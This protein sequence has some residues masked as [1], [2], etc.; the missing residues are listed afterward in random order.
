MQLSKTWVLSLG[1]FVLGCPSAKSNTDSDAAA[2]V[3]TADAA[4]T[5]DGGAG[6]EDV[7][8]VYALDP[9][10]PVDPRAAKLCAGL[11]QLAEKKRAECCHTTPGIVLV[12]ECTRSLSAALR[13]KAIELAMQDVDTCLSAQEKALT[14]CD[15]VGP[16]P[17]GPPA[18]CRGIFEGKVAAGQKC[19]SSL[20]CAGD[21]HCKGLGPT[22]VGTCAKPSAEGESCGGTV[23][24]LAGFARQGDLGKRHPECQQ[25]CIKHKCA[26]PIGEGGVCLV[27]ADCEDGTECIATDTTRPSSARKC[28]RRAPARAGETCPG[29]RCEG[30]LQC[31]RGKC[32]E[33]KAGGETCSDDF[34][35][36]G[37]C[38]KD[39]T[40]RGKCGPRC[41]VR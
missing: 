19:R 2:P 29:G 23:D 40:G 26:A 31:I 34:E 5:L 32:S 15:W 12:D 22:T 41:D 38:L 28:V 16:F 37:G 14:G 10:A 20:E 39:A 4:T 21:L 36:R 11:T 33:R 18:E 3:A 35:C 24:A 17:P 6:N 8:P 9:K 1:L 30:D 13:A 27:S 25:R 7:T